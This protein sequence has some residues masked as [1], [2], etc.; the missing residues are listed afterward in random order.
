MAD[1]PQGTNAD[2]F[3]EHKATKLMDLYSRQIGTFGVE[4]MKNLSKLSILIVGAKGVGV[5]AAKDLILAGPG[6]VTVHDDNPVEIADL[7]TNFFFTQE[8]V[9]KNRAESCIEQLKQLNPYV[10]VSTHTGPLTDEFLTT[11]G[12]ILVTDNTPL[13]TVKHINNLC[14]NHVAKVEVSKEENVPAPILFILAVTN[15]VTAT[16][17][18]DFGPQHKI[19]DQS[20]ENARVNSVDNLQIHKDENGTPYLL[21]TVTGGK[22]GLEED[23]LVTLSEFEGLPEIN[24][25]GEQKIVR[26][27]RNTKD[28]KGNPRSVL[29]LNKIRINHPE[30]ANWKGEYKS[31]GIITEVKPSKTLPY[32][33]LEKSLENP[34]T[35]SDF[36]GIVKHP[37]QEKMFT[38]RGAQLHFARLALWE[39]QKRNGSLPKLHDNA[40]AEA[41]LA[42]AKEILEKNKQ[43]EG[44]LTVDEIDQDVIKN[45]ALYAVAELPGL[46]A[47]LGGVAAQEVV[48]KFGRYT[49]LHQW[50]HTDYFELLKE[51]VPED[52]KPQGT[53]YDHQI[54]IF[55]QEFQNTLGKQR[56]FMVGCGALGCEYLKGLSLMGLG[57]KGGVLYVTDM[58]TIEVSNLSRQFLFRRDNVGQYKSTCAANAAKVMNP[59]MNI[60]SSEISVGPDT[61]N[62]FDDAFWSGLDG[63]C[64]AL[65]NIK[66]REYTDSK[67]VFFKKPLLESGTLGTKA[68][69]EIIIPHKTPSY[70]QQEKAPEDDEAIPMCTLRNFP[71]LIEHCIEW[72]R[73]AFTDVF[74]TPPSSF[75]HFKKDPEAFFADM[76]KL[77]EAEALDVLENVYRIVSASEDKGV[78]METCIR[79]AF[80]F[81]ITQFRDRIQNLIFAFPPDAVKEDLDTGAK[82]PFWSGAKRFPQAPE[83]NLED[84][85]QFQFIYNTANLYA[86]VFKIKPIRDVEEFKKVAAASNLQPPR[87]QPSKSFMAKVQ[88][89]VKQEQ[90]AEKKEEIAEHKSDEDAE[91]VEELKT[92]LRALKDTK[93]THLEKAEFEK[94]DDT[95]FHIDFI[96]SCANMRA[97]NYHI[98]TASRHKCKMIAGRIIPAVATTTA[99]VTGLVELE[100]YKIIL[101]LD[102]GKFCNANVNLGISSYE[103]FEPVGPKKKKEEYDVYEMENV[104]PI[105]DGWTVWDAVIVD[106]GDL[107][108]EELVNVF[109]EVHHGVVVKGLYFLQNAEQ[110]IFVH[111]PFSAAQ[112]QMVEENKKKKLTQIY[113]DNF[114]ALPPNR[115]YI[116]LDGSYESKDGQLCVIPP[117]RYV[118]GKSNQ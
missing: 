53:R 112:K 25:L 21:I 54:S 82:V 108:V 69:T 36:P 34:I 97:W 1:T 85:N 95:N 30:I 57:A 35:E 94:D 65:D 46:T 100:L 33:T 3:D 55:G 19:T 5:E 52:A 43:V 113:T 31:G 87:W 66:A 58:D 16:V 68:N 23:A 17:F 101:G 72:A 71:H 63:V 107:T 83:F 10:N 41:V 76:D 92:K 4:T 116:L 105:P 27:Y 7:G 74:V 118:F 61:E 40:D 39:F 102:V 89:E 96:T 18:T 60:I 81:F 104:I 11:F 47:F 70:S 110:P 42:I 50:M 28:E 77:K 49:P 99:M 109:P 62:K 117:V 24:E 64:N 80:D 38:G 20:G 98:K 9:G 90:S 6:A 14:H 111:F 84:E 51:K 32:S 115:N 73:A 91:K 106:K 2:L 48:K 114:G 103:L 13:E 56:W 86:S 88:N 29:I 67:C 78:S 44:A 59:E 22:H 26:V 93:I 8:L 79:L 15:G 12:A 75:N 45:T 37:H